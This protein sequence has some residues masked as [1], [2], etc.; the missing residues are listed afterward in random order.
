MLKCNFSLP[1]RVL[2]IQRKHEKNM[3]MRV[4]RQKIQKLRTGFIQSPNPQKDYTIENQKLD[5]SPAPKTAPSSACTQQRLHP[6]APAPAA[7]V[8][9]NGHTKRGGERKTLTAPSIA[10]I[11]SCC[12]QRSTQA[13][14]RGLNHPVQ[15]TCRILVIDIGAVGDGVKH[16]EH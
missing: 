15:G 16:V 8:P 3:P 5:I 14:T 1:T 10:T 4:I 11:F 6:A 7:P 12:S 9:E 2:D 13:K